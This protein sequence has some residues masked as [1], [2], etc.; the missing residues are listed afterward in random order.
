M[1]I[2]VA[3]LVSY[4]SNM[5]MQ[6]CRSVNGVLPLS[7]IPAICRSLHWNM[8]IGAAGGGD[9]GTAGG[10]EIGGGSEGLGGDGGVDG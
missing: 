5:S 1:C 2:S 6:N 3:L 10:G 4:A 7:I 8:S 9:G